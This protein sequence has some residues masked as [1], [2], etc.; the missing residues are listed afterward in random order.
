M[1]KPVTS[2]QQHNRFTSGQY[3]VKQRSEACDIPLAA[4]DNGGVDSFVHRDALDFGAFQ[5]LHAANTENIE[6]LSPPSDD[7]GTYDSYKKSTK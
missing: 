6:P 1:T 7:S 2:A 4:P 5:L 3:D